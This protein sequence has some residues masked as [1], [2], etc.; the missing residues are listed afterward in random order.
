M[1]V[2]P[3]LEYRGSWRTAV[4]ALRVGYSGLA[5]AVAGLI[6]MSFGFTPGVLAVGVIIWLGAAVVMVA[7]FLRTL[8]EI[9]EPRPGFWAMRFNLIHDTIHARSSD[10][11]S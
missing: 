11:P 2:R 10:H 7:G 4:W 8:H 5:I 1:E 3:N 9:P 6:V